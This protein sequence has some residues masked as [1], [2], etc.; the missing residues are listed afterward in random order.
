MKKVVV[1]LGLLLTVLGVI[2]MLP[3]FVRY[4]KIRAM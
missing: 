3:D 1:G 4:V 2:K